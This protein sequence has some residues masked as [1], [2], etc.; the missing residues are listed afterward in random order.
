MRGELGEWEDISSAFRLL[1]SLFL[2]HL[3]VP[4]SFRH[5]GEADSFEVEP[6]YGAVGAIASDHVTVGN[7]FTESEGLNVLIFLV[8]ALE[9]YHEVV[10]LIYGYEF[11]L[12]NCSLVK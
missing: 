6:F 8:L 9:L 1:I 4:I 10:H 5:A 12:F 3:A 7:C 11:F 2:S